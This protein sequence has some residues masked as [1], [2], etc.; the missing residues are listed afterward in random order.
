MKKKIVYILTYI[1]CLIFT[2]VILAG[3]IHHR[4]D[5]WQE[6]WFYLPLLII[7]V[8]GCFCNAKTCTLLFRRNRQTLW[9]GCT[10]ANPKLLLNDT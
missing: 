5:L 3:C 8:I 10:D 4:V 1:F 7:G 9:G 2:P 6:W